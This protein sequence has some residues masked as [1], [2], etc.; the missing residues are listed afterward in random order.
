VAVAVGAVGVAAGATGVVTDVV[1]FEELPQPASA[2][3]APAIATV[4]SLGIEPICV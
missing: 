4:E 1:P 2:S 3:S